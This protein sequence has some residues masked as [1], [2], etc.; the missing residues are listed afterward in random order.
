LGRDAGQY[1]Y[2]CL[3][4]DQCEIHSLMRIVGAG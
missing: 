4:G 1:C 2:P 3:S